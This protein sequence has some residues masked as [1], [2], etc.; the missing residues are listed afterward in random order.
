MYGPEHAGAA[1]LSTVTGSNR[2][3]AIIQNSIRRS[4]D[5]PA[6]VPVS[7]VVF[8]TMPHVIVWPLLAYLVLLLLQTDDRVLEADSG[9]DE[10]GPAF[11]EV[12]P[13]I[14]E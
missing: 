13:I 11:R 3:S 6:Q 12:L 7:R 9:S 1:A 10:L 4:A 8:V 2:Q 14:R 5:R